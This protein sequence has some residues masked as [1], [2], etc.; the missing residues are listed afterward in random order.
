MSPHIATGVQAPSLVERLRS[1]GW[2][3]YLLGQ[4]ITVN[5][6]QV[7]DD[8]VKAYL[9]DETLQKFREEERG[10]WSLTDIDLQMVS[11]TP[12]RNDTEKEK[13]MW[14]SA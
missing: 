5:V 13:C 4:T 7:D 10:A 11:S 8:L 12:A 6:V 1:G 14:I 3:R 2:G 9:P